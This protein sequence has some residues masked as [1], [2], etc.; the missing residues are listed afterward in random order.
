VLDL[1]SLN[2]NQKMELQMLKEEQSRDLN[3]NHSEKEAVSSNLATITV[4]RDT[5]RHEARD[6]ER[7]LSAA[8]ADLD[9]SKS[10]NGRI[11]TSHENL[12][13]ALEAFQMERDSEMAMLD[14]QRSDME[15]AAAGAHAAAIDAMNDAN[16]AKM[17]DVQLAADKAIRNLMDEVNRLESTLEVSI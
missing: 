16:D 7:Q 3:K 9:L 12:Q 14:E 5:A 1:L 4:E 10:D 6:L 11:M 13:R 8:I 17:R 2:F 15:A